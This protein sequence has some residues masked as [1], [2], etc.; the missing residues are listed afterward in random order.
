M[1]RPALLLAALLLSCASP[2]RGEPAGSPGNAP[3]SP[4]PSPGPA[5]ED[6]AIDAFKLAWTDQVMKALPDTEQ[7]MGAAI[8]ES[9]RAGKHRY[10][11]ERQPCREL[12][13][14]APQTNDVT[15]HDFVMFGRT[16]AALR[17]GDCWAVMYHGD[18]KHEVLGVLD[19]RST[20]LVVWRIPEG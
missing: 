13:G 12:A 9:M 20:L 1:R 15:G 3:P 8:D 10:S 4:A 19:E 11:A 18:M 17:D 16:A 2:S 7:R 5:P 14:R 6:A